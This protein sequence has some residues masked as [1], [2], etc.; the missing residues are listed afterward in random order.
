M[1]TLEKT[2]EQVQYPSVYFTAL[3]LQCFNK[4]LVLERLDLVEEYIQES[5]TRFVKS[6]FNDLESSELDCIELYLA[7]EKQKAHQFKL[8]DD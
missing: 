7:A 2:S 1:T 4:N 3:W 5:Y 8:T 6:D